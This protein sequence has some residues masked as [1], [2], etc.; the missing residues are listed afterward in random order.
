MPASIMRFAKWLVVVVISMQVA[1]AAHAEESNP[2]DLAQQV[3]NAYGI[4][5][6]DEVEELSF[7]FNVKTPNKEIAR[8]W[9][10]RPQDNSVTLHNKEYPDDLI[11]YRRDEMDEYTHEVVNKTDRQFIND[12]YWLLFPFQL[13]WSNPA[14][15][16]TG[17]AALPVGEGEGRKLI[18]QYPAEGGY[19][20]GDA[21]DIYL[22]DAGLIVQ[23][24][25]RKGG[26]EDGRAV[27][28]EANQNLGPIKVS[29]DHHNPDKTFRLWFSGLSLTTKDGKHYP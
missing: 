5:H 24:V 13:V 11:S 6:W 2:A 9:T 8:S 19:T 18:A 15:T 1:A 21:Y 4:D 17:P 7:T 28:W 22:D 12:S 3:A 20:P 27:T 14:I 23:W 25:F 26:G 29:A 16:D 10:W